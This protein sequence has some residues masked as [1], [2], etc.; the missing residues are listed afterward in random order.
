MNESMVNLFYGGEPSEYK[1]HYTILT[2]YDVLNMIGKYRER[3]LFLAGEK[4]VYSNTGYVILSLV[5]EAV[6]GELLVVATIHSPLDVMRAL[7]AF[8]S[9]WNIIA[10]IKRG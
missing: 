7:S 8:A 5:V 10:D 4:Y 6:S 2:S 1:D 9:T 3:R